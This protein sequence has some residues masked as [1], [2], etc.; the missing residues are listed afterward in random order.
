MAT[1]QAPF[2]ADNHR[3]K[4][5]KL[6][7][8]TRITDG[9]SHQGYDASDSPSATG[10]GYRVSFFPVPGARDYAFDHNYTVNTYTPKAT[11]GYAA[12]MGYSATIC[13]SYSWMI[14]GNTVDAETTVSPLN[15]QAC[16]R[17]GLVDSIAD[18]VHYQEFAQEAI[19]SVH[20]GNLLTEVSQ[21]PNQQ[22]IWLID[23]NFPVPDWQYSATG[24]G[25]ITPG[26]NPFFNS[27]TQSSGFQGAMGFETKNASNETIFEALRTIQGNFGSNSGSGMSS[28]QC[29]S[30]YPATGG[31]GPPWTTKNKTKGWNLTGQSGGIKWL[32]K[33]L[34]FSGENQLMI[35]YSP[36]ASQHKNGD[37][38]TATDYYVH[39]AQIQAVWMYA[40]ALA[41][42]I[43]FL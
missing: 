20:Y 21:S 11:A 22:T 27:W 3:R 37:S 28:F 42:L 19:N 43:P 23:M 31:T 5:H 2:A 8:A 35:V 14:G 1:F 18:A 6:G 12:L 32:E 26:V 9:F 33:P 40:D 36:P 38:A 25:W 10:F 30:D 13:P 24:T 39:A 15:Q 41:D 34:L 7:R 17:L 29:I 16:F 4:Y